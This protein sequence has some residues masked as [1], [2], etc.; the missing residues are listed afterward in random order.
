MLSSILLSIKLSDIFSLLLILIV[1]YVFQFYYRYF[2]RPNPL[3]GPLPL[4]LVGNSLQTGS[5]ID[6]WMLSL[7][8]KYGDM[9]ELFLAG[10]RTIF[11]CRADLIDSMNVP[12][13]TKSKY[14]LRFEELNDG[15]DEYGVNGIGVVSNNHVPSWKFNRQFFSQSMMTPSFNIQTIEWARELWEEMESYWN[16]LGEDY[17]VDLIKWMRRFTNEMIFRIATGVKNDNVASYYNTIIDKDSIDEGGKFVTAIDSFI[18]GFFYIVLL[19]KFTRN[20]IP[21]IRG[22]WFQILKNRDYLFDKINKV[23]KERRIEIENTPL[24]QPLRH[25]MLTAFITA[26]TS[27]DIN[28]VKNVDAEYLRPMTDREILGN[29]IDAMTGGTDTVSLFYFIL[30]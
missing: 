25:D 14:P 2:T 13:S 24:D 4:P 12:S 1:T 15:L 9:F 20:Y 22:Q 5:K 28:P 27:R 30:F 23:I 7:H 17:E 29:V 10:K 16:K 18:K 6:D 3:P 19:N 11:V 8:K 21:F 26:N